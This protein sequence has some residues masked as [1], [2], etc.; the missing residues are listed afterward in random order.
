MHV[1]CILAWALQLQD[2]S[3]LRVVGHPPV[4][5]AE[6]LAGLHGGPQIVR[7]SVAHD[8]VDPRVL[9]QT[10][11]GFFR[12]SAAGSRVLQKEV[13]AEVMREKGIKTKGAWDI[14]WLN[15]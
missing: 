12:P 7:S 4:R 9:F 5:F 15:K 14:A 2:T 10:L 6:E 8:G 3:D 1:I 11:E 13:M